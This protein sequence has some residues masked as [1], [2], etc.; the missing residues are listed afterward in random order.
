VPVFRESDSY[1]EKMALC[2]FL[3][4]RNFDVGIL[5]QLGLVTL[6]GMHGLTRSVTSRQK[7]RMMRRFLRP[8]TLVL[9]K[10]TTK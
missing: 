1:V 3:S 6:I 10:G 7:R 2:A 8:S 9:Q 4:R 5:S